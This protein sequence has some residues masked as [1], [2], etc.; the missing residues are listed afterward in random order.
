[1][2]R[3]DFREWCHNDGSDKSELVKNNGNMTCIQ[4][5]ERFMSDSTDIVTYMTDQQRIVGLMERLNGDI[6]RANIENIT[7][8]EFGLNPKRDK[9][10]LIDTENGDEVDFMAKR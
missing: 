6:V 3:S 9:G 10:L 8:M 4:R 2:S 1:M 5:N 7:E